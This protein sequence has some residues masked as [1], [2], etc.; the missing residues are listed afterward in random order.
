MFLAEMFQIPQMF[1]A[2]MFQIPQMFGD[3]E[4]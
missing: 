4:K 3:G 2:E 1:L